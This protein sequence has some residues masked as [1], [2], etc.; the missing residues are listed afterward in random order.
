MTNT[1]AVL[2]ISR[3]RSN[4]ADFLPAP[5]VAIVRNVYFPSLRGYEPSAFFAFIST[6]HT[7]PDFADSTT[8]A[9]NS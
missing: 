8:G 2:S 6:D 3:S 9:F 1:G 7:C 5:S 4:G